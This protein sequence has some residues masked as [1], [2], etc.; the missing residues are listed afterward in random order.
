[1]EMNMTNGQQK[2]IW[3]MQKRQFKTIVHSFRNET[4]KRED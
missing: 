4:Y 1:M 2:Q 3:N